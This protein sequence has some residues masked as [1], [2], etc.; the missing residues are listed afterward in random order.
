MKRSNVCACVCVCVSGVCECVLLSSSAHGTIQL[1]LGTDP[2][3][4]R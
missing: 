1:S 4:R 2:N 3:S